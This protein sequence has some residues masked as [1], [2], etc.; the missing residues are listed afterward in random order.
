MYLHFCI[1]RTNGANRL[2]CE[3]SHQSQ[4]DNDLKVEEATTEIIYATIE[5]QKGRKRTM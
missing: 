2:R 1:Q 5:F 3:D 4:A